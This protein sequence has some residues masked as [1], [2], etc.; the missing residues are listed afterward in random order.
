MPE[1]VSGYE[2]FQLPCSRESTETVSYAEFRN[3]IGPDGFRSQTLY[4]VDT[5]LKKFS[6]PYDPLP[7]NAHAA[8]ITVGGAAMNRATY[9][10][11]LFRRQKVSGA[12]F[13]IQSGENSQYYLVEFAESEQ[14][15]TKK[16]AALYA[17]QINLVQV[18]LPDVSIFDMLKVPYV[19]GWY[20]GD[21]VDEGLGLA[22][23]V[24]GNGRNLNMTGN[25]VNTGATQAGK[26]T[27]K[28]NV[29][30]TN[31]GYL[32]TSLDPTIYEAF[33]AMKI[34]EAA[35]SNYGGI[36]TSDVASGSGGAAALVGNAGS[37]RFYD[38]SLG[39]GLQYRKNGVLYTEADAQAPMNA[40]GVVHWRRDIGITLNNMQIGK[41]RADITRFA[42]MEIGEA[43]LLNGLNPLSYSF[44]I[45]EHLQTSWQV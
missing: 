28:F 16:L 3:P 45:S 34:N 29:G 38:L 40:W 32:N 41:D 30:G 12:P 33:F 37:T 35:F 17:T 27:F 39:S 11:D 8:T 26:Q 24:S 1:T 22:L 10:R 6:I 20:K 13:A 2:L 15:L 18:R 36:L 14:S 5:G 21:Y 19:W 43:V 23:D 4:G 42:E 25:V 31:N 7:G 44:E 9:I